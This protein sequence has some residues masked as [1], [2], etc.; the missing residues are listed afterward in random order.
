MYMYIYIYMYVNTLRCAFVMPLMSS[1]SPVKDSRVA[2]SLRHEAFFFLSAAHALQSY[3][4]ALLQGHVPA[5]LDDFFKLPFP[6]IQVSTAFYRDS[7]KPPRG[8]EGSHKVL[9]GDVF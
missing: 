2:S 1:P 6:M 4:E 7:H 9:L 3:V 8:L 5:A